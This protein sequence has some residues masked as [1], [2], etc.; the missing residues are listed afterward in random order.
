MKTYLAFIFLL[1]VS[2]EA[3]AAIKIDSI[4]KSDSRCLNTGT[5]RIFA[6]S[7]N[8][9]IY[10][11]DSG[12]MTL[13]PQSSNLFQSLGP[14]TYRIILINL[15][16]EKDS[17]RIIINSTYQI[18][19][20][21]QIVTNTTCKNNSD[22]IV[23]G[24]AIIN[25]GLRPYIWTLKNLNT[26]VSITQGSDTFQNLIKGDYSLTLTDS[27][28]NTT[29]HNF[30]ISNTNTGL[31]ISYANLYTLSCDSVRISLGSYLTTNFGAILVK[32]IYGDS[33]I[34]KV[35]NFLNV[36]NIRD[37]LKLQFKPK[38]KLTIIIYNS[39]GDSALHVIDSVRYNCEPKEIIGCDSANFYFP[40]FY[41][42]GDSYFNLYY[43]KAEFKTKKGTINYNN[44]NLRSF[45]YIFPDVTYGDTIYYTLITNCNDTVRGIQYVPTLL[46]CYY[47]YSKIENYTCTSKYNYVL[48]RENYNF[49][50]KGS[51][52]ITLSSF[53]NIKYMD[54]FITSVEELLFRDYPQNVWYKVEITDSCGQNTSL[55]FYWNVPPPRTRKL[56]L[57]KDMQNVCLDSTASIVILP[58]GFNSDYKIKFIQGPNLIANSKNNYK[59]RD[60]FNYTT[61][62]SDVNNSGVWI[63]NFGLGKYYFR[64]SDSCGFLDDSFEVL[65][66]DVSN[67]YYSYTAV[68]SCQDNNLFYLELYSLH[69]VN[70]IDKIIY[71]KYSIYDYQHNKYLNNSTA[72]KFK[73][74]KNSGFVRQDTFKYL[75]EGKYLLKIDYTNS[76]YSSN[77]SKYITYNQKCN[78]VVDTIIIPPYSRP[79]VKSILKISCKGSKYVILKPDSSNGILPYRY[80][81]NQGPQT[82]AAQAS[83]IFEL[84][85][86]G[87]YQAK[88][89]D[90]CGNANTINFSIDT[91]IFEPTYIVDSSC[92]SAQVVLAYESSSFFSYKWKHPNGVISFGDTLNINP[93]LNSDLGNYEITKRVHFNGC[94]DS[95]INFYSI[96][97]NKTIVGFDTIIEGDSIWFN[98]KFISDSGVYQDTTLVSNCDSVYTLNLFV[99]DTIIYDTTYSVVCFGDSFEFRGRYFS[100]SNTYY[101]TFKVTK[102]PDTIFVLLL[103]VKSQQIGVIR[104]DTI[105]NGRSLYYRNRYLADSGTYRD[106][107]H[108]LPC[109]SFFILNLYV[110]D[111]LIT[112][113]TNTRICFGDSTFHRGKYYKNAGTFQDTMK[114]PKMPDTN[115]ILILVVDPPLQMIKSSNTYCNF[116]QNGALYST[117]DLLIRDTLRSKIQCDSII[118]NYKVNIFKTKYLSDSVISSCDWL[119]FKNKKYTQSSKNVDSASIKSKIY[120][121][122]DSLKWYYQVTIYPNPIITII[123]SK[124]NPLV[125][126]DT[127]RLT[128]TGAKKYRWNVNESFMDYIVCPS[129]SNKTYTAVGYSSENC[130]DSSTYRVLV[131]DSFYNITNVPSAFTP[132]GDGVNDILYIRTIGV[133]KL[134]SFKIFNR[135]GQLIY[136]TDNEIFG[137]DGY[138][139]EILQNSDT[140]F[141]TYEVETMESLR[142]FGQGSFLLLK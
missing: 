114:V 136:L 68:N 40:P 139:K 44:I 28:M 3:G 59:Y 50:P 5:I 64:I 124:L 77:A 30:A 110:K 78:Q 23:V 101:D 24:N 102:R 79:N 9:I 17:I 41:P 104:S 80:E 95:S 93:I 19:D 22:G 82:F 98:K 69:S 138:Y 119:V 7:T 83:N 52:H 121:N 18:P 129:Y 39:C 97:R 32:Y 125:N 42:F 71:G 118:L 132:N 1:Y 130:I 92:T 105:V 113:Q 43:I 86:I 26:N 100:V 99:K 53:S 72:I 66:Q 48:S 128:A 29:V 96:N 10:S 47:V 108:V 27:C 51:M 33:V 37:D 73:Y 85:Q 20:F 45:N 54:T 6:T 61:I 131:I 58:E 137:W 65:P 62:Y 60:S 34:L 46:D 25:K 140:Y 135:S 123:P 70:V 106:T 84:N 117:E 12:P 134:L 81:I 115:F 76:S 94:I 63:Q 11:I 116:Y 21:N 67:N 15:S 13:S 49:K 120:P 57:I 142:K 55:T 111:T 133:K 4:Q 87:N 127:I 112:L 74:D 8:Q 16:N 90:T 36:N 122:C 89:S 38:Q 2:I 109:D 14:G 103:T 56:T 35:P 107:L 91:L 88:I 31:N 141:Y 126:G 75:S